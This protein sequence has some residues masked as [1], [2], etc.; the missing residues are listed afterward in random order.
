MNPPTGDWANFFVAE[1]GASAALTGLLVVAISINLARILSFAQLPERAA[2][3]LITLVAA[4]VL[5]GYRT[6]TKPA[7]QAVRGGSVG[8][9]L[10]NV[11]GVVG[12]PIA[13]LERH[14]ERFAG[15]TVCARDGWRGCEPSVHRRRHPAP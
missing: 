10:G 14:S 12:C 9:R 2:E 1:V 15:E 3:G 11:S 8:H 7:R 5:A 4:F 6:G 13:I